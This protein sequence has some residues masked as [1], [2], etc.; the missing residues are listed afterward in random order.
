M[1]TNTTKTPKSLLVEALV[2]EEVKEVMIQEGFVDNIKAAWEKTK[3]AA[4]N[5][6]E[7][8]KG[9][10]TSAIAGGK[11]AIQTKVT[12][13]KSAYPQIKNEFDQLRQIE[14]QSGEKLNQRFNRLNSPSSRSLLQTYSQ[15]QPQ[16][17]RMLKKRIWVASKE[18]LVKPCSKPRSWSVERTGTSTKARSPRRSEA[19]SR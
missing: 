17:F 3:G 2:S 6:W 19:T 14:S 8:I 9:K 5:A 11:Q 10:F 4:D 16:T 1:T 12:E 13:L 7:S 15:Q 18:S